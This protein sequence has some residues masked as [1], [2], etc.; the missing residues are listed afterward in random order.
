MEQI[1]PFLRWL[2][3][4]VAICAVAFAYFSPRKADSITTPDDSP[5]PASAVQS[6]ILDS[7]AQASPSA[8]IAVYVCGAV[9]KP[10]G[11]SKD[12]DPEAINL[13]EPLVDGMKVDVPKKGARP[14]D[15]SAFSSDA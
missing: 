7:S 10:G 6:S 15:A 2:A 9:T 8:A 3:V 13:A 14:P 12:A 5:P 11:L 4:A 1:K